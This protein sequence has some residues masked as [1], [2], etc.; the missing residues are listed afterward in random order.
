MRVETTCPDCMVRWSCSLESDGPEFQPCEKHRIAETP[1][2]DLL[3]ILGEVSEEGFCSPDYWKWE[4]NIALPRLKELGYE[5]IRGFKTW[6]G[7]SFGPLTRG[8]LIK[9]DGVQME[10]WY[11]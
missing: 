4:D 6:D 8:V 3:S 1:E 7:D 11:G 5:I 10:A 9:K 2:A